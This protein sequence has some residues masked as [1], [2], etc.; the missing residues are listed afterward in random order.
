MGWGDTL[1]MATSSPTS[2]S[3]WL[4]GPVPDL[5]LGGGL[6]YVALL[7]L[8]AVWGADIRNG[9]G[10]ILAPLLMLLFGTPHHG[11]TLVRVY[12]N[13]RDRRAYR[14][15]TV[16][17]SLLVWGLFVVSVYHIGIGSV[18][19]TVFLTWSPWHYTGQNYG[20]AVMFLR[21]RDVPLDAGTKRW[22]YA[23]FLLSYALTFV[24]QHSGGA[25]A[26]YAVINAEWST[27][28]FLSLGIPRAYAVFAGVALLYAGALV[29]SAVQLLRRAPLRDVYPALV[30][31]LS[32]S[33]WF[34]V[35]VLTRYFGVLGGMD[36]WAAAPEYYFL[37]VG[38]GHAVQYL[39]VTSYYAKKSEG[40]KGQG[41]YLARTWLAGALVWTLPALIFAPMAFGNLPFASGLAALIS[42]G[43]NLQHFILDG[44]IWKLRDGR[45]ARVLIR[46]DAAEAPESVGPP[47]RSWLAPLVWGTGAVCATVMVVYNAEQYFGLRLGFG[48]GDLGR[49]ERSLDR[50][51][52]IG[53]DNPDGRILLGGRLLASR[54]VE[55]ALRAYQRAVELLPSV[56]A[57]RG[58]GSVHAARGEWG[59]AIEAYEQ[60]LA[61]ESD[62]AVLHDLGVA[63]LE[64]GETKAAHDAFTRALEQNPLRRESWQKLQRTERELGLPVTKLP[65]ASRHPRIGSRD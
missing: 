49:A 61:I 5:L 53:R 4:Y 32:Q 37:W 55:G 7:G 24:S 62:G 35:P 15:F 34:S 57:W 25:A 6:W 39:W 17:A 45:V 26:D 48:Y 22:L 31:V 14:L 3:R 10:P 58:I 46:S 20:V 63:W 12:E 30:L 9:W 60:A 40:W 54:D 43:V 13:S 56:A 28:Q 29:G 59:A 23:T 27:Y 21:R 51:A 50:L 36:A 65:P 44:A 16:W 42:A 38:C 18:F 52:W 47:R 19:L 8:F 33:L 64:R 41:P 2:S 1:A 11:A